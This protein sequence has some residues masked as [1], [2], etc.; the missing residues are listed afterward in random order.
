M[1]QDQTPVSIVPFSHPGDLGA[2]NPSSNLMPVGGR[3]LAGA[4]GTSQRWRCRSQN[5]QSGQRHRRVREA[6]GLDQ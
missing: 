3:S 4:L 5:R 6:G 2:G 1:P